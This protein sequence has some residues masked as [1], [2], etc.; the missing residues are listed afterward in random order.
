MYYFMLFL[1]IFLIAMAVIMGVVSY[2]L[3]EIR[4]KQIAKIFVAL[5]FGTVLL[6]MTLPSLKSMVLKEYDVVEGNCSIEL[7]STGRYGEAEIVMH[8]TGEWF[9]FIDIPDL[10]AYGKA[11][12]YFCEVTVSKNHEFIISYKIYDVSSRELLV[13][14]E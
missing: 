11:I 3:N 1:G 5:L 9:S 14:S 13:N 6:M 7:T 12:P 8:E 2:K 4:L 10:D